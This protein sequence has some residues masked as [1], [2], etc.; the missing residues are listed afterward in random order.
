MATTSRVPIAT[1][2]NCS[3]RLVVSL[4]A[5]ADDQSELAA[6]W[7][8]SGDLRIVVDT[9]DC[10]RF[11]DIKAWRN[12][13]K[14]EGHRTIDLLSVYRNGAAESVQT[15]FVSTG[16]ALFDNLTLRYLMRLDLE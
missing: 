11:G 8:D 3:A 16:S 5:D 4:G 2:S 13:G 1:P 9:H 14:M 12:Q 7:T 15:L 6:D 10:E